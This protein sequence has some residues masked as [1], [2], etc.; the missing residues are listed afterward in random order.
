[1]RSRSQHRRQPVEKLH[2]NRNVLPRRQEVEL[3]RVDRVS[4]GGA[5]DG[6]IDDRAFVDE[7]E[8]PGPRH[9]IEREQ[10]VQAVANLPRPVMRDRAR[11]PG[12]E[13]GQLHIQVAIVNVQMAQDFDQPL[14]GSKTDVASKQLP[15]RGPPLGSASGP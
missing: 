5:A 7:R 3:L 9:G 14:R 12:A 11:E 2:S 6:G 4:R 10:D 13:I 15:A 1:M 8:Q